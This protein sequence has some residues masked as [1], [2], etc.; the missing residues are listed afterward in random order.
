MNRY[1]KAAKISNDRSRVRALENY[2]QNPK[3][4]KECKEVIK[5]KEHEMCSEV[6][7]KTYCSRSC[8]VTHNNR[9]RERKIKDKKSKVIK[10]KKTYLRIS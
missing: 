7:K 2:Y 5:V 10:E 3:Y 1:Q 9:I 4:C 8:S 6:R